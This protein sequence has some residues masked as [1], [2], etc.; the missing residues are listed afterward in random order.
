[1][2]PRVEPAR[3][4]RGRPEPEPAVPVAEAVAHLRP[5]RGDRVEMDVTPADGRP[6]GCEPRR[7]AGAQH[8]AH[9][10]VVEVDV[11]R[12][13]LGPAERPYHRRLGRRPAAERDESGRAA[14]VAGRVDDERVGERGHGQ[15]GTAGVSRRVEHPVVGVV[16]REVE[17]QL[18]V[19]QHHRGRA[20]HPAQPEPQRGP[21]RAL[22][23]LA[24]QLPLPAAGVRERGALGS[25][26]REAAD[27]P[28]P[29]RP[30]GDERERDGQGHRVSRPARRSRQAAP[31]GSRRPAGAPKCRARSR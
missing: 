1:M 25:L 15:V 17:R 3:G 19:A 31:G 26:V 13:D 20:G 18:G 10:A 24:K 27:R 29:L 14:R 5:R 16:D 11:D 23:P 12:A 2:C 21:G 9:A 7:D 22:A 6:A 28:V 30:T 8:D 4:V